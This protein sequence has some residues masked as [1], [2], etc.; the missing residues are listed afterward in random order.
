MELHHST[1]FPRP[2]IIP[3]I[4][5]QAL[6]SN[7]LLWMARHGLADR[8][9]EMLA[10]ELAEKLQVLS[11]PDLRCCQARLYVTSAALT[12]GLLRCCCSAAE[13]RI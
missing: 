11:L 1:T 3:S 6:V 13:H 10:A 9:D 5:L 2:I 8:A 7:L 12:T 4:P